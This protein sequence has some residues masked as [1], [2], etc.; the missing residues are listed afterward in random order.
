M[1]EE[2]MVRVMVI[3][4]V[5]KTRDTIATRGA[6]TSEDEGDEHREHRQ[7]VYDGVGRLQELDPEAAGVRIFNNNNNNNNFIN[8]TT[9]STR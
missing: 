1:A 3:V 5:A 6:L 9:T 4:V 8:N 7:Q 2:E